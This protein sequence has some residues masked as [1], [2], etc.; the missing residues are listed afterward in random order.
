M[1]IQNIN[2]K[3]AFI[4]FFAVFLVFAIVSV[5]FEVSNGRWE[6]AVNFKQYR[7]DTNQS[8]ARFGFGALHERDRRFGRSSQNYSAISE[9]NSE[10]TEVTNVSIAPTRNIGD[11]VI[12]SVARYYICITSSELGALSILGYFFHVVFVILL[13]LWVYVDSKKREH[14]AL[15]WAGLT[16]FTHLFGWV[17]YMIVR[18]RR[19]GNIK[20]NIN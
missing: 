11:R 1:K 16:L 19:K 17:I 12:Y 5:S 2:F 8:R 6:D 15:L 14:N 13:T 3:K 10:Q 20:L 4:T 9:T 7:I 18:E